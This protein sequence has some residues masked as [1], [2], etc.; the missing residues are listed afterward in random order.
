[1]NNINCEI[2]RVERSIRRLKKKTERLEKGVTRRL[3][4]SYRDVI[5]AIMANLNDK[6]IHTIGKSIARIDD[7]TGALVDYLV[8]FPES[9]TIYKIVY[10]LK[11][12]LTTNR[13][14]LEEK[15]ICELENLIRHLKEI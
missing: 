5:N 6:E 1:M 15:N 9:D 11:A 14:V 7:G 12:Y 8:Y 4:R 2:K 3:G 10:Y 13:D